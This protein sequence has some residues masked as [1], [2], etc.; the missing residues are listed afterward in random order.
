[1]PIFAMYIFSDPGQSRISQ[2]DN[3]RM[4]SEWSVTAPTE[5][6]NAEIIICV[7]QCLMVIISN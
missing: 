7:M 4:I 6:A 1:M 3:T 5:I 2:E